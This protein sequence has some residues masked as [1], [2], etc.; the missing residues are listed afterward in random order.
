M[1]ARSL[2]FLLLTL[3]AVALLGLAFL[4]WS[5]ESITL[6]GRWDLYTAR[7][8]GGQWLGDQCTGHLV[9]AE[10]YRFKVGKQAQEIGFDVVGTKTERGYL[11]GCRVTDARNWSCQAVAPGGAHCI[12]RQLSEGKPP[13]PPDDPAR[14]RLVSR[15]RWWLLPST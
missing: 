4:G 10:Q 5:T 1:T 9:R 8:Q 15:W 13:V 3:A 7:C 6:Q 11:T 2:R 12:A 14:P